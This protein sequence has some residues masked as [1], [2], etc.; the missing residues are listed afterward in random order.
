MNDSIVN[1]EKD[2]LSNQIEMWL[3]R[4]INDLKITE[5]IYAN[6]DARIAKGY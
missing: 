5:L 1:G 4:A 3:Q 6:A 2:S